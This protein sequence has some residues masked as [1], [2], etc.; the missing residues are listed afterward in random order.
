M[1]TNYNRANLITESAT[2]FPNNNSQLISPADLRSWLED[3]TTSF[4]T[5]KDKSTLENAIF[6][7]K[8]TTLPSAGVVNLNSAT[9]NY[10]HISGTDT[11]NSFGT[12]PAGARFVLMFEGILTLTY[13]AT[14]L[15][16]PGLANK[17]TAAGDCCMIVSEG[18]G[19]WRIV[20]YFAISGGG[21]G[22]SVTAV[23]GTA[24]IASSGG[25]APDISITQA[26]AIT[27]GYLSSTDWNTFNGKGN[28]TITALTGDVTASGTGSVAATIASGAVD[29]P[30]LSATGTPSATTFLRG[31]NT[32]ATPSGGGGGSG[33]GASVNYYLNG[34][35]SQGTFG[36]VACKE[37]N[38]TPI[39][40]AGTDF[41]INANG[42]IQSFIT[43]AN[44]PNQL[45]IPPGNWIFENYFSASSGGGSPSFYPELY[46][47]DGTSL[48][49]IAS[50]SATPEAITGGTSIDL[51]VT[52][53]GVPSTVLAATD[54]LVVRFY[55]THSSRT[56]TM[57]T[58]GVHLSEI[59][60]TFSTGI[61]SIN[62]L[63][64]QTQ[65]FT[66][67]T[68]GTDFTINSS[69]NTHTFAIPDASDTARG[70][71]TTGN[72][73][74]KGIKTFGNGVSAG[75]IR[76]LEG[77]GSGTNFVALKSPA[78]L[79]ADLSLTFPNTTP[80]S[81]Q[82]LVSDG[83]GVLSWSSNPGTTNSIYRR[84]Y[85]G[86]VVNT[87]PETLLQSLLVPANTFTDGVGWQL[88][89]TNSRTNPGSNAVKFKLYIN[90]TAAIGGVALAGTGY[91]NAASAGSS[92]FHFCRLGFVQI[93]SGGS[94][95]TIFVPSAGSTNYALPGGTLSSSAID[96][97][98]DQ[99]F[100]LSV[101]QSSAVST[102]TCN[103]MQ[104]IP[105]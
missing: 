27:D 39:F 11:I 93:A 46:K 33:G 37:I 62:G 5:Q 45:L 74:L 38:R 68:T 83:S 87:T 70:L 72:Q 79:G 73:T 100:V 97:S 34:S 81:G 16:I 19:N 59:V 85:G 47:W 3:G 48:T 56:I 96:W 64:D 17:T 22:G 14:S 51:Y 99:Y 44:D 26:D 84:T 90:T 49:L 105:Q 95:N 80:G 60:T 58:E 52:A 66:V 42:Y 24:P 8:G 9:G 61:T 54:R 12:C 76:F 69:V 15:I 71:I 6:E 94:R 82:T 29:I 31:D 18:S 13:N 25:A 4:V 65:V 98:I 89:S 91:V 102:V 53:L 43:D 20:G 2:L 10:L 36:G 77:S 35:V 86:T 50:N 1:P 103:S 78:T 75:E 55:V 32:W 92:S 101:A 63:T 40:G 104:L 7:A 28:G 23:T 21:G 67:A 30:M 41:T 88:M 57:H